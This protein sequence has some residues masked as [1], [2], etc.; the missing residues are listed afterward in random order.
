MGKVTFSAARN[1]ALRRK[2]R[3]TQEQFARLI[4]RSCGCITTIESR[5][6]CR[7]DPRRTGKGPETV[8]LLINL[9]KV[10]R[11]LGGAV[12]QESLM[13]FLTTPSKLLMDFS[14]IGLM[15]VGDGETGTKRVLELIEC[16]GS[17]AFA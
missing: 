1:R 6:G 11:A 8:R 15:K 16:A 12:K 4:G 3:M 17:G 7:S 9:E 14:P 2:L 13:K 5:G 10:L